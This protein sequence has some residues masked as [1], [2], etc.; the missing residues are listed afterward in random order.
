MPCM[1]PSDSDVETEKVPGTYNEADV[2]TKVLG[3]RLAGLALAAR[4]DRF[5][6]SSTSEYCY[7]RLG[8]HAHYY[9]LTHGESVGVDCLT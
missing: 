9:M 1:E 2:A 3:A 4:D 8:A 6:G 5:P 7:R